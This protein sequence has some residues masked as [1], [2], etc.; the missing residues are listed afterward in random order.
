VLI[1]L[2][3]DARLYE[4]DLGADDGSTNPA[5]PIPA[6]IESGPIELSSEGTFDKGDRM[7]FVRRVLPDVTFRM[8]ETASTAPSMNLV[9]KMQDKP[10]GGFGDSSSSPVQ[11]IATV[12]IEEF[13][14]E[15]YVRLR[16]RS[17]TF[18]AESNSLGTNWRLGMTRIDARTDGQR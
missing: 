6:F 8:T 4:H 3:A 10:G 9:F 12:P 17:L 2:P 15:C 18:R 11:R 14:E 1:A 13:T 5:T 7:M 16:G